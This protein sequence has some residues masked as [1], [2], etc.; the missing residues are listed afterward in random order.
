MRFIVALL[1]LLAPCLAF[2]YPDEGTPPVERFSAYK[3][4][5]GIVGKND[6]KIQISLKAR[7][8]NGVPLYFGY[9]QLMMWDIY[10]S[11]APMR[12]I[13]FNP[14][15]FYRLNLGELK[16][17]RWLDIGPFEHES[18]GLDG[19]RSRSW[20]RTY[21]RYSDADQR[22]GRVLQWSL[23]LYVPYSCEISCA[24]YR[25]IAE[26]M[27]SLNNLFGAEIG[28]NDLILR[29]YP[30]GK[31]YVNFAQGGQEITFR[32]RPGHR[33]LIPLLVVQFFR[34]YGENLLDQSRDGIAVRGGIGF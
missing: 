5:Y 26:G 24:R 25:G 28:E 4:T 1:A 15:V 17:L 11:S 12:D 16:D 32:I 30:G 3:P 10:K 29:V 18:N 31:G 13:N 6:A 23:K 20:N 14:E 7:P 8:A 9:T 27:V 34:G 19:E 2:A 21:V 22:G 33:P